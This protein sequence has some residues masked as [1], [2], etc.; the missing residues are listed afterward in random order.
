MPDVY[1]NI[2]DAD[3]DVLDVLV[4]A[5][6]VRAAEDQ[7]REMR[8]AYLSRINFPESAHVLEVGCGTGAVSRE[9]ASWPKIRDVTAIDPSPVFL[10]KARELGAELTNLS[11]QE[12]D[13]RSLP[14]DDG[15]FDVVI[16]HTCLCHV[17]GPEK[18]LEEAFRVLCSQGQIA[19]FDGD[20]ATTTLATGDFDPLQ[21][22]ADAAMA[23]LV[24]DR[25][26]TRRLPA[27]AQFT[28]FKVDRFDSHG[29]VQTS[30]PGYMLTIAD[31][32]ADALV[33]MGRL[34]ARTAD[35]LKKE[36]RRRVENGEFYGFIAYASLIAHKP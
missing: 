2:T 14:F 35:A 22:C 5:L 24:H 1:A 28:G 32:G 27:L 12:A 21:A 4:N 18:A 23:A 11:F 25:W 19:I 17:P 33:A 36:A 20:Y 26:L 3:P 29:Y 16:F 15:S 30:N 31:R 8:E 34:T 13:A 6:E 10:A 7:Q 9:L